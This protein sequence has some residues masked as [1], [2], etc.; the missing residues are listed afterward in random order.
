M[1]IR[2]LQLQDKEIILDMMTTFYSSPA[3]HTNGSKEIFLNDIENCLNECPYLE[4]YAFTLDEKIIGYGMLAKSF[5]TEFG[6]PCIWIEDLYLL[7]EFQGKGY[8]SKFIQFVFD[9]YPNHVVRLEVEDDN[10]KAVNTY[11]KNGFTTLPYS[12]MIKL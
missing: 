5:S 7:P 3:V 8:G 12:E 1:Q 4:G 9:S 11:R 2:P 10:E 6:K